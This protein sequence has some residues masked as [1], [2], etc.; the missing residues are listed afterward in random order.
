VG[1]VLTGGL[2][3]GTGAVARVRGLRI[4]VTGCH[5]LL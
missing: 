2:F 5:G 1:A 3:V 4:T